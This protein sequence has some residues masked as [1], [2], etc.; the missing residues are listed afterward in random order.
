MAKFAILRTAKLKSAGQV[1][2]M[3]KHNFRDIDTPNA[4]ESRTAENEHLTAKSVEDGMR[5][6]RDRLPDKVRKNAVHAI[7][8]LVTT[9][10]GAT[11]EANEQAMQVAFDWLCD[12]HGHEN[13]IM[14]SK[15]YD[16]TTPHAHFLVV[17]IDEK[18][19]L[20]ARSFIGGTKHRMSELQDEFINEIKSR[21]IDLERGLKGS[22]ARHTRIK[23]FYRALEQG[24]GLKTPEIEA[25]TLKQK[26]KG[27]VGKE[28]LEDVAH[29]VNKL[30]EK[31]FDEKNETITSLRVAHAQE[32][33]RS[34]QVTKL[35]KTLRNKA[36]FYDK[37]IKPLPEKDQ[38]E[39]IKTALEKAPKSRNND[40]GLER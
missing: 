17:P 33:Q 31:S 21:D 8:Y 29:R 4:D 18:G 20:N 24:R 22:K 19:K 1:R 27:F 28:T 5:R 3:L 12:K 34:A 26:K 23:D 13:V 32:K 35:N 15:H 2:G 38:K 10:P 40:K 7:D 25:E 16:E 6:Y 39:I 37:L 9:S 14:A 11:E 36:D 30:L